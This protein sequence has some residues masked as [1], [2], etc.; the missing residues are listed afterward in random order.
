V[1]SGGFSQVSRKNAAFL[2]LEK[3]KSATCGAKM[4]RPLAALFPP[5]RRF[6]M[7][8]GQTL[9]FHLV[10]AFGTEN[11]HA[12]SDTEVRSTAENK[13][14]TS[15]VKNVGARFQCTC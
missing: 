3:M 8:S 13:D 5:R 7:I 2:E 15:G 14:G 11:A 10:M 6:A 4:R 1:I 9:S 12:R